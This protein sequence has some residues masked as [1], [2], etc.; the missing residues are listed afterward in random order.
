[1][2]DNTPDITI[3]LLFHSKGQTF[4]LLF[5]MWSC[6]HELYCDIN[7]YWKKK[8]SWISWHWFHLYHPSQGEQHIVVQMS[9]VT[10]PK[11]GHAP[12]RVYVCVCLSHVF[13]FIYEELG[14]V[15][16]LVDVKVGRFLPEGNTLWCIQHEEKVNRTLCSQ[17]RGKK[18]LKMLPEFAS[19]F[20]HHHPSSIIHP[21][22]TL[23]SSGTQNDEISGER[24][25]YISHNMIKYTRQG[26]WFNTTIIQCNK[27]KLHDNKA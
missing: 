16:D 12:P 14:E 8:F 21:A 15:F 13:K 4:I 25:M 5:N 17:K 6:I 2:S 10:R 1:M 19:Q 7:C 24:T 26:S 23:L 22:P 18:W 27:Q 3:T 9:G 20:I 11:A